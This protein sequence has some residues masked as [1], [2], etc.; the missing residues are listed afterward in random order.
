MLFTF[1]TYS[2]NVGKS[3]FSVVLLLSFFLPF[4]SKSQIS[5]FTSG[6]GTCW[7]TDH[8]FTG[9]H[10]GRIDEVACGSSHM[11]T[12]KDE[13]W[14][15]FTF[16]T[17]RWHVTNWN[18]GVNSCIVFRWTNTSNY[19]ALTW[20]RAYG[21]IRLKKD[22]ANHRTTT[23]QLAIYDGANNIQPSCSLR[24]VGTSI[25]VWVNGT[26]Q[27]DVTDATHSSGDIGFYKSGRWDDNTFW[28]DAEFSEVSTLPVELL[29]FDGKRIGNH[30]LLEWETLSEINNDYFIIEKSADGEYWEELTKVD[31]QGNTTQPTYY[32]QID[33][34]GCDE[35]CYYRLI[36]VDFGGE[37]AAPKLILINE[38]QP[39]PNLAISI[40]PNPMKQM[41]HIT[42]VAPEEGLFSLSISNQ[43]GKLI[44]TAKIIGDKGN[45]RFSYDSSSLSSGSYYFIIEDNKG[46]R[47]QQLVIK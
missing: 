17:T 21:T 14:D 42:F 12:L 8:G 23:G 24:V 40:S 15:D 30:V 45:N 32:T 7:N 6:G 36:Q 43:T 37:R 27:I 39:K 35:V 10:T 25:K 20:D 1:K 9:T 3:Y 18:N 19:Y 38:S 2:F 26:L 22:D 4:T 29:Y 5:G 28:F 41:V 11:Y 31:G 34:Y 47:T 44:S 46:N 33:V 13:S 16:E